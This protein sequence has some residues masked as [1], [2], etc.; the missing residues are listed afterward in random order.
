MDADAVL[1]NFVSH[2]TLFII[3]RLFAQ[4]GVLL[5]VGGEP[6]F[7]FCIVGMNLST[8]VTLVKID[9]GD[10]LLL[11]ESCFHKNPPVFQNFSQV[12]T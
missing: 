3:V 8:I 12:T 7:E 4:L 9:L 1:V 5:G 2:T 6:L 11:G 10:F